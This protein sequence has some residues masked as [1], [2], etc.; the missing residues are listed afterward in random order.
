V[1]PVEHAMHG[2]L[3]VLLYN[4]M[5]GNNV[6]K[7]ILEFATKTKRISLAEAK[8]I[9][10]TWYEPFEIW[11]DKLYAGKISGREMESVAG[12]SGDAVYDYE[13][14]GYMVLYDFSVNDFR[15]IVWDNVTKLKKDGI[16]YYIK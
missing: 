8:D 3:V 4:I 11:A 13:A 5:T 10:L 9:V 16:T 6:N 14:M 15:T 2:L 1:L 12:P 7:K